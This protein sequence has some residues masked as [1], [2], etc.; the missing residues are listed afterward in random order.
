MNV[1]YVLAAAA[2]MACEEPVM[3]L[4]LLSHTPALHYVVVMDFFTKYL[5]MD[6]CH[7]SLN[8]C[9]VRMVR[10]VCVMQLGHSCMA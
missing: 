8:T 10:K 4:A 5:R 2:Q 1:I 9:V 6:Y 7:K 3:T